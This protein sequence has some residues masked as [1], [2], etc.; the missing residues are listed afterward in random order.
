[1]VT[2]IIRAFCVYKH[3][4]CH[5]I[6]LNLCQIFFNLYEGIFCISGLPVPFFLPHT[7]L[8]RVSIQK[9]WD[10]VNSQHPIRPVLLNFF[11]LTK[12][13]FF[14]LL[15]LQLCCQIILL[16][17]FSS[18]E[19]LKAVFSLDFIWVLAFFIGLCNMNFNNM[20]ILFLWWCF[21]FFFHCILLLKYTILITIWMVGTFVHNARIHDCTEL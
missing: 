15:N 18:N 11:C 13:C 2:P 14:I 7:I 17:V 1:M 5:G 3:Y 4:A 10:S 16:R 6:Y 9:S 21:S 12:A 8:F 19:F 20:E